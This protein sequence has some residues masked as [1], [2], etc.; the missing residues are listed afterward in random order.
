MTTTTMTSPRYISAKETAVLVR[1]ALKK[2]FPGV[3][4]GVTTQ[5]YTAVNVKWVDGPLTADVEAVAKQY[6]GGSFDGMIDLAY[7]WTSYLAPDGSAGI[8]KSPGTTGSHYPIDNMGELPVGAE[9]VRFGAQYVTC[10]RE[11]SDFTAKRAAVTA[12]VQ[13]HCTMDN[14]DAPAS[15]QQFGGRY[16]T[17]IA[18]SM[19]YL[20]REGESIEE[21]FAARAWTGRRQDD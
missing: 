13:A 2:A 1:A 5:H 12:W 6:Q 20:T 16:L 19:V 10:R 7:Q 17:D 21:A 4:F 14:P 3:K 9:L 11:I 15:V 18:T 8:A